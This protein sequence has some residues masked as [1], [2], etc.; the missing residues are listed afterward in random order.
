MAKDAKARKTAAL[1]TPTDLGANATKDLTGGLNIRAGHQLK[2]RP[3]HPVQDIHFR[4]EGPVV[5]QLQEVFAE[6]WLFTTGESLRDEKWFPTPE[7]HGPV[8]ARGIADGPDD[9]VD[10][11]RLAISGALA[12]VGRGAVEEQTLDRDR[13]AGP[14]GHRR[15]EVSRA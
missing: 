10:P 2:A 6:D 4:V 15:G 13:S 3:S 7:C 11:L 5:T 9:E 12:A 14:C 1:A 8:V